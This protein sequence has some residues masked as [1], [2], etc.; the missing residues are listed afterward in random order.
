MKRTL[1]FTLFV[2]LMASLE[3][4][5][6]AKQQQSHDASDTGKSVMVSLMEKVSPMPML[7]STL[8]KQADALE[9]TQQQ[10]D[11]FAKWRKNNMAPAMT[12]ATD[13]L[14]LERQINSAALDREN[15]DQLKLLLNELMQKRLSLASKMLE[16]RDNVQ[17]TLSKAQWQ[18]L[19]ELYKA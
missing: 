9:L 16:C 14:S 2:F 7:M 18:R 12:L 11:T 6:D 13:I 8:V 19:V 5:A 15:T 4:V 1:F 3:A 10:I 17:K